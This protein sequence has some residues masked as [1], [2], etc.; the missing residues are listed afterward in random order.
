MQI[1][2]NFCIGNANYFCWVLLSAAE[3]C[4]A[5]LRSSG[6]I[7]EVLITVEC[8]WKLLS[9]SEIAVEHCWDLLSN[10]ESY[11]AL[12]SDAETY[13][14]FLSAAEHC[15][16]LLRLTGCFWELKSTAVFLRSCWALLIHTWHFLSTT[17]PCLALFLRAAEDCWVYLKAAECFWNLC[18]A[19]LSITEHCW[20]LLSIFKRCWALL[21]AAEH[22]LELLTP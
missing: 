13:W 2:L 18:W 20:G 4:L 19:L 21:R 15:W 9:A 8:I 6:R 1:L 17:E 3:H 22:L 14:A 12:L 10:F 16:A 7:W 5:L 11:R